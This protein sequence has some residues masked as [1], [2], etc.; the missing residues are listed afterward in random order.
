MLLSSLLGQ[1]YSTVVPFV[2][3]LGILIFVHELGHF[4]VAR[5]C[6]VRVEVFSL[7]FG[8]KILNYKRGDT[9]YCI[10]LIPLGGYVKMFGE[11]ALKNVEG[12]EPVPFTEE[13]KKVSFTHKNVWQ[14][15]AIVLA[16][17]LMNFFFAVLVFGM[18]AEM[19]EETRAAV[20]SEVEAQSNA[21]K[22]G[23]SAGDRILD[24][25]GVA[26][27][28]Y[29]EFQ[30]NLNLYKGQTVK[31]TIE[32]VQKEIKPVTLQVST[33]KNPNI[34]STESMIGTIEGIKALA[35]GSQ[36]GIVF[37]SAAAK[38]GFKT[39]DEIISIDSNKI[40]RW[41]DLETAFF[42]SQHSQAAT[43]DFEVARYSE[44]ETKKPTEKIKVPVSE[45]KNFKSLYAFG[46]DFSDLYLEQVVKGSPA[47]QADLKRFDKLL[48]FGSTKLE[49]WEEVLTTIKSFDG[50]EPLSIVILRDGVEIEK[51]ITPLVTSQ[52]TALGQEDK[53]Y[54]IGILPMVLFAQ[55]EMTVVKTSSI[56]SSAAKGFSRTWDISSMTVFSFVKLFQGEVSH[57]NIGG[58]IS[59]GKAA[60]DSYEMGLQA[61]L[62]TMGILSVSLFIL[63]LLPIPVL[64]GGHLVFYIIEVIKGSPLSVKKMEVAQQIGFALLMGLMVLAL[65][66]DFTKFFFKA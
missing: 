60:K 19:G 50:K 52:M 35:R 25:N 7:G 18:I 21:A 41:S 33:I 37:D 28:S 39:G 45:I 62:M 15:I 6:G 20:I 61:F 9:T 59:I 58:M 4:L 36:V 2:L 48:S 22:M 55:P 38:M 5:F 44:E 10:S 32:T 42:E 49:K 63:N 30:K 34:F 23:L 8:K 57:K 66:N 16:G 56:F 11:Q 26:V 40:S 27:Q 53:R 43:V 17:P 47:E 3:L 51:K 46:L 64:D 13:E 54:T 12:A 1:I 29:E 65:F 31:A 24:V 14:R